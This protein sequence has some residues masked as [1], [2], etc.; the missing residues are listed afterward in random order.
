MID[1]DIIRAEAADHPALAW[2]T[3]YRAERG[4]GDWVLAGL[5]PDNPNGL[6]A[7]NAI[8]TAIIISL[9]TDRRAPDGWRPDV[10][11]RRGWWGD[12][13]EPDGEP[14][15]PMGSW[16]WLLENEVVTDQVVADAERYTRLALDW[17]IKDRVCAAVDVTAERGGSHRIN[18]GIALRAQSGAAI[19][20]RQYDI[21]WKQVT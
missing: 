19:Y 13:V 21:L 9:F 11:D 20:A 6:Q 2:D 5:S 15:D 16:L 1:I 3:V 12:A 4:F 7:K 18:I 8:A 14:L 10:Q 17:M